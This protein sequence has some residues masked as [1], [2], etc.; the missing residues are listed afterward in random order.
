VR[1][2]TL[3]ATG[4]YDPNLEPSRRLA[5]ALKDAELRELP[6]VGHGSVLQRPDFVTDIVLEFLNRHD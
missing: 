2:R 1:A 3:V 5:A 6:L 4:E